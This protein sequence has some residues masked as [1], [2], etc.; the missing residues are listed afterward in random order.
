MLVSLSHPNVVRCHGVLL[1]ASST[2]PEYL[3]M[4]KATGSLRAWLTAAPGPL[5]VVDL[6]NLCADILRGLVYIHTLEPTPIVHRDL[7]DDNVLVFLHGDHMTVKLS[8]VDIARFLASRMTVKG[9]FFTM[10]PELAAHESCTAKIDMYSFAVMMSAIVV[11]YVEVPG[12][13]RVPNASRVYVPTQ[14]ELMAE[15]VK[16]LKVVAPV[17]ATL[18]GRCGE[19]DPGSR[20]SSSEALDMLE[21]APFEAVRRVARVSE[22]GTL[23]DVMDRWVTSSRIQSEA[24]IVLANLVENA[25]N[26]VTIMARGGLQRVFA[27]MD[28]HP[29]SADVQKQACRAL[30]NLAYD[31]TDNQVTIVVRDGLRRLFAA[32]DAHPTSVGVQE[33][34]CLALANLAVNADNKVT[35]MARDGLRHLF[36][37][38]DAHPRSAGVQQKACSAL[39]YL[40][41]NA[42]NKV[43]IVAAD[44]LQRL[45][46]AMD[47]HPMS[48][49]VQE[50][51]CLALANLAANVDNKVAIVA[52]DGL[53][54]LFAAMDAHPTSFSV[55][56]Q[57]CRAL[58]TL[59]QCADGKTAMLSTGVV[60]RLLAAR[61]AFPD[62]APLLHCLDVL[63]S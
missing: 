23:F 59:A 49:G 44:G 5:T 15:T 30:V 63:R 37:A 56:E 14:P 25:D 47:T 36:A 38:M 41:H 48:A 43:V 55:M 17:L 16:R 40:A 46:A 10:A 35:L 33:Y 19:R 27:A 8:D 3:V 11:E 52:C 24:I 29:T 18:M 21:A 61:E 32:M 13:T 42:D 50:A 62:L 4:E 1:D 12:F 22:L 9:T 6:E 28:A 57:V 58:D 60:D 51:T 31:N 7:K 54:R 2:F 53:R 39:A 45:F 26:M 34:A 20:F